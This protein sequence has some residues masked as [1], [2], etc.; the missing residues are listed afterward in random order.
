MMS[1]LGEEKLAIGMANPRRSYLGEEKLAMGMANPRM[2]LSAFICE[3][4]GGIFL[5]LVGAPKGR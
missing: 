5:S 1:Y 4:C 2:L 3:I